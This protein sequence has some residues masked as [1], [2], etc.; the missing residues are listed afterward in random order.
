MRFES[1]PAH[2]LSRPRKAD[3]TKTCDRIARN[4]ERDVSTVKPPTVYLDT[5][6]ISAYWYG[7]RDALGLARREKTREWWNDEREYFSVRASTAS[8]DELAAGKFAR[9]VECLRF[10]RKL[11]YLPIDQETRRIAAKLV[12]LGVVP[13]EKP[14]DALQM[15]VCVVH[16]IDYLLSWNYA[17]LVNPVAQQHLEEVCRK[18]SRR[19]PLLVSPESIPKVCLGQVIR[20]RES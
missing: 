7:G 14:G 1:A 3:I 18:L 4:P 15:S 12:E 13:G 10:V 16:R 5:N 2:V 20:R 9:Q 8:E 19:A 11:R 17:H 6:I